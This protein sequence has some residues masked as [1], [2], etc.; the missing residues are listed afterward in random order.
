MKYK[1]V[2]LNEKGQRIGE[3]H[4]RARLT[5]EDVDIIRDLHEEYGLG[6]KVLADKFEVSK[7]LIRY[8][9]KYER[10][11][12]TTTRYKRVKTED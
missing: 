4:H 1:L 12:Q 2:A 10:R 3:T 7:S 11:A 9:C 6:Y 8:I 5:D